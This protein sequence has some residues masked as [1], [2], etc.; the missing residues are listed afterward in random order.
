MTIQSDTGG[1]DP[2]LR[3]P[4]PGEVPVS[5]APARRFNATRVHGNKHG[6]RG[7]EYDRDRN[8]YRAKIVPDG[9]RGIWLGRYDTP[10]EAAAAYDAAA[11]E[12]YG[13]LAFLNFPLTGEKKTIKSQ[14]ADGLCANGHKIADHGY[15]RP[16][17]RGVT[18]RRCNAQ[19]QARYYAKKKVRATRPAPAAEGT[20]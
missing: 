6:Y 15:V 20:E 17:G 9:G 2:A 18:C 11:S 14:L 19:A 8:K 13:D 7:V 12:I 5:S 3:T 4:Q 1:D 10:E 16:D